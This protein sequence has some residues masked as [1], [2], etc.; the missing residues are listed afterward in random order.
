MRSQ[1]LQDFHD[2]KRSTDVPLL[3]GDTA[4]ILR[5]VYAS[6][7]GAVVCIDI[8]EDMPKFLI[9]FGDGTD[10]L[11]SLDNLERVDDPAVR[12]Q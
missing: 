3:L 10:E 6:R 4:K 1:R 9:E 12:C 11:V 7:A 2:G 8:S 5:G